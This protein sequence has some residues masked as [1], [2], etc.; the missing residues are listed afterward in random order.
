M[1]EVTNNNL[2]MVTN[3]APQATRDQMNTLFGYVGR[4]EELKLYPSIRD[5][6]FSVDSRCCF[7]RF[8]DPAIVAITQ[9]LNNTVF[10][11]RAI[12]ITPVLDNVIPDE[13]VGLILAQNVQSEQQQSGGGGVVGVKGDKCEIVT[14]PNSR[15]SRHN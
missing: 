3:I 2:V 5:A 7:V 1:G 9:H 10:I 12:I 11:D 15:T 6:S 14:S 8:S 4:V 13:T